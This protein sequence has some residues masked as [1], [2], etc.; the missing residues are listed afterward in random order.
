MKESGIY[1]FNNILFG[2]SSLIDNKFISGSDINEDGIKIGLYHGIIS[3]SKNSKGFEFSDK[4][5]TKFD[6][7]D[8]V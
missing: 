6:N 8:L 5:I 2:V 4:S 1:R 7:Y 3:N